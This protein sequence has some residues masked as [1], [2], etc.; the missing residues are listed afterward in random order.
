MVA[1]LA[2]CGK[3]SFGEDM[4]VPDGGVLPVDTGVPPD[5]GVIDTGVDDPD[6][7]VEPLPDTGVPQEC[8]P[9]TIPTSYPTDWPFEA[10]R[11]GY[12]SV[13][14]TW[15]STQAS[16]CSLSA[17]HGG[18]NSPRIPTGGNLGDEYDRGIAELWAYMK[19]ERAEYSG[20]LWRH[21]QDYDG[22]DG[23]EQPYYEP[24]QIE[25]LKALVN[26]AWACH[27]APE[28]ARQDAGPE[29]GPPAAPPDS[30]VE[31]DAGD[32]DA[33]VDDA[34]VDAGAPSDAG[35][36]PPCYC[37]TPDVGPFNTDYCAQ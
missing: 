13:F 21:K 3:V 19:D 30:G 36:R 29:C 31:P 9:V 28:I 12:E 16:N 4:Q 23:P 20:R 14:W 6:T 25:F 15:A 26:D 22:P 7:G 32:A 24:A 17:C 18:P 33:G 10:T 27:A 35:A 2:G 8:I 37:D 1:C 34:E 11:A 5:T